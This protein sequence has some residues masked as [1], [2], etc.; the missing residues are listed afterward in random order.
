MYYPL[1]SISKIVK[2]AKLFEENYKKL[3]LKRFWL[4]SDPANPGKSYEGYIL[5][6]HGGMA[7]VFMSNHS[8]P[9]QT[10]AMSS[11]ITVQN[12]NFVALKAILMKHKRIA[13]LIESTTNLADLE[14]AVISNGLTKEDLYAGMRKLFI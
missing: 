1:K 5:S 14:N 6:E 2:V 13:E 4:K 12:P 7:R 11:I 8:Q 10:I 9:F 3:N